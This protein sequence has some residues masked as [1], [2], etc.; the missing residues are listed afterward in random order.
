MKIASGKVIATVVLLAMM[1]AGGNLAR[2]QKPTKPN[3]EPVA[4]SATVETPDVAQ[5]QATADKAAAS[6]QSSAAE[7]RVLLKAVRSNNTEEAKS[8]LLKNGFTARQLKGA[9]IALKDDTGGSTGGGG[10]PEEFN[11][12]IRVD[13][14]PLVIT[15][16]ISL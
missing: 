1:A 10:A 16:T 3:S 6:I 9:E 11:I 7:K 15:I 5:L 4:G 2:A 8:V 13:C 12:T 14:C